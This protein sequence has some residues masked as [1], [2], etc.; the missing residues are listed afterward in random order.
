[1]EDRADG[2]RDS[3][4]AK[5]DAIDEKALT[6]DPKVD[7]VDSAIASPNRNLIH[8]W[9]EM[10]Q[11]HSRAALCDIVPALKRSKKSRDIHT[12]THGGA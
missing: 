10:L 8:T 11:K 2:V 7:G 9:R 1:M 4:G 3:A 5:A 12:C 6:L